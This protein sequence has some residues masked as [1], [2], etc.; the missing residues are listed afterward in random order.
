[1]L[2]DYSDYYD[3]YWLFSLLFFLH[4]FMIVFIR[5]VNPDISWLLIIKNVSPRKPSKW[6]MLI[7]FALSILSMG[8][9]LDSETL[10]PFSLVGFS[11]LFYVLYNL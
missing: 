4:T 8:C 2:S 1:M 5:S 10:A 3:Y 11:L 9:W 6:S 7:V